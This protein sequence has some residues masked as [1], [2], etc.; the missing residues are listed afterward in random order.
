MDTEALRIGLDESFSGEFGGSVKRCLDRKGASFRGGK[1]IGFAING[2]RGSEG[3]AADMVG[4]HGLQNIPR[5]DGALFQILARMASAPADVGMGG[6]MVDE[7]CAGHCPGER[8]EIQQIGAMQTKTWIFQGARQELD[9]PGGK[10][11]ES[12]H[13]V[14]QGQKPVREVTADEA[15]GACDKSGR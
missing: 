9:S 3:N 15:G 13:I 8:F 4:A 6:E 1:H 10:V 12:D 2:T 7:I 11:V 14:P 5:R